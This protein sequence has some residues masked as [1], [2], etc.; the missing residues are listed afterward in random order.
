MKEQD[1]LIRRMAADIESMKCQMK[2]KGWRQKRG[3]KSRRP[4]ATRKIVVG[5]PHHRK[6]RVGASEQATLNQGLPELVTP[7][8]RER[9]H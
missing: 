8:L 7:D 4:L 1:E 2:G 9:D 5:I 3:A 6:Q